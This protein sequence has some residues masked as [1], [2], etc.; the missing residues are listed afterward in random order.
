MNVR[1][2]WVGPLLVLA[3]C[4]GEADRTELNVL[5]ASSLTEAFDALEPTYE[6][7]HPDID[8]VLSYVCSNVSKASLSEDAASTRTSA[9]SSSAHAVMV[10][11][12]A[13]ARPVHAETLTGG[14]RR[15]RWWP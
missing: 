12:R 15:P 11:S 1:P 10:G 13:T 2:W 14:P 8:V 4:S 7:E 5:A 6:G 3:A 9:V